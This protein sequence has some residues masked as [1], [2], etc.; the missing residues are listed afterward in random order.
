MAAESRWGGGSFFFRSVNPVVCVPVCVCVCVCVFNI[1]PEVVGG[2]GPRR[3]MLRPLR[4]RNPPHGFAS[5]CLIKIILIIRSPAFPV[6][7][8]V[9][10]SVCESVCDKVNVTPTAHAGF[11]P[12]FYRL[13][14]K[15]DGKVVVRFCISE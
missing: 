9:R 10:R 2:S 3:Q 4:T 1:S 13:P 14:L 11:A 6:S 12:K 8:C 7:L 15:A 5:G